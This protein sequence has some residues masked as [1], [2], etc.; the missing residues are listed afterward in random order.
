MRSFAVALTFL[1]R[2]PIVLRDVRDADFGRSVAWF[3]VVGLLL[4]VMLATAATLSRGHMS[5]ELIA[6]SLVTLLV[7]VTG[8]LHVD[9]VADVFDGVG[10][11]RGNR[12]RTLEIMRDSHIGS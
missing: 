4:G 1:T 6:L 3:P 7:V 5:H 12:E 9:G 11:G 10:G 2:T 8:G